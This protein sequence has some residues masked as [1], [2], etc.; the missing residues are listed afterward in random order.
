MGKGMLWLAILVN[1]RKYLWAQWDPMLARVSPASK[2]YCCAAQRGG[3]KWVEVGGRSL[4]WERC[5]YGC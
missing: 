2:T 1:E 5:S 4:L 3:R